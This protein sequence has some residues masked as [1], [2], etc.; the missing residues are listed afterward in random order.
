MLDRKT[1]RMARNR[2]CSVLGKV[3]SFLFAAD[4]IAI[5]AGEFSFTVV[6]TDSKQPIACRVYV[7]NQMR[8]EN[9]FV[10][11]R[12][13]IPEV[14][15][16][17]QNWLNPNSE[18]HHTSVA[19]GMCVAENLPAG[20][21]S[22][23][24]ENGKEYFTQ[25]LSF[26]LAEDEIK[27]HVTIELRR[28]SRVEELGWYS[29][30]T[31]LHRPLDQLPLLLLAEDLNVAMPIT[32]W[33]IDAF[34][35]PKPWAKNPQGPIP[36]TLIEVD[37]SHV[38]WPRNTEFEITKVA[39][40]QHILG[41]LFVLNHKS[42]IPFGAPDW[43]P[44]A[45]HARSERAL[46]DM[47]K[48][49]WPFAMTLPHITGATLYELANNHMWRTEF[50]LTQWVSKAP[51]FLQPPQG[52]GTGNERDWL[53]YTLGQYYTLLDA[54]FRLVPT[55]GTASGV[56]PVPPGFSRV[57]VHLSGEFTY[58]K[59]IDGLV[60]G[61]SFVT[62]GPMIQADINQSPSGTILDQQTLTLSVEVKSV[63]PL[64]ALEIVR[65]GIVESQRPFRTQ[66]ME[67]GAYRTTLLHS[68]ENDAS[69]WLCVRC[70]ED[71]PDGRVRFAHTAPWWLHVAGKPLLPMQHEKDYLIQRVTDEI[72]RSKGI[73]PPSALAEYSSTLNYFESLRTREP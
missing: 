18:E 44:I 8:N 22:L 59:W 12:S 19:P 48:L 9:F 69:G 2:I 39:N 67:N 10:R 73:L 20:S 36:D 15:Y 32:Y 26:K 4:A 61:K 34:M 64:K 11:S 55:A 65:N 13:G 27:P 24:V 71:R 7:R 35:P 53:A 42:E 57:Y 1:L 28:W 63:F 52:G 62:T 29:G 5:N 17:K 14:P 31:H 56:H 25:L 47:D 51:A 3:A 45:V 41:A 23:T 33:V 40:R 6:D 60:H 38:I 43:K 68:I 21:Y 54:G 66:Q 50:G 30:E 46:M 72:Q 16:H 37:K 70:I 58:D 49:D